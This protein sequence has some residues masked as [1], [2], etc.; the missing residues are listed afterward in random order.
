MII[1][2]M[3]MNNSSELIMIFYTMRSQAEDA[4]KKANSAIL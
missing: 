2:C 4:L 1:D 3:R